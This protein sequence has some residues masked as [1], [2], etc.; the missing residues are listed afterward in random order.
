M[1]DALPL[2]ILMAEFLPDG[3]HE[4]IEEQVKK[5]KL[6][7]S[8]KKLRAFTTRKQEDNPNELIEHR[9]LYRGGVCLLLGPTGIGKSS[10]LMQLA[11]YFSS[12][13]C[14]QFS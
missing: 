9:F 4:R 6:V 5:V 3:W 1:A 2:E 7:P 14:Q 10:L 8:A 13:K 12:A 11:I